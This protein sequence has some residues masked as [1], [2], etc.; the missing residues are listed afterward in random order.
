MVILM[1]KKIS[2]KNYI[3]LAL[4]FLAVLT[5][6]L[7]LKRWSDVY[8]EDKLNN[9]PLTEKIEEVNLNETST[10]ISE[11]NEVLIYIGKTSDK[12]NYNM[13]KRI[14]K[15]F[16]NK[17]ILDKMIYI[18]VT[19]NKDYQATLNNIFPE[20]KN[21][22]TEAPIII[23]LKSGKVVDILTNNNGIIY[24]DDLDKFLNKNEIS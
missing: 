22:K 24:T 20:T 19:N 9:S 6:T 5:L 12:N 3:A 1:N 2:K 21:Y 18:N 11:M 17:N 8:K 13:E 14:L 16:T 10:V 23:Y 4:L 15:Y 7:Y